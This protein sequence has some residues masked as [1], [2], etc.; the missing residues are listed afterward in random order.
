MSMIQLPKGASVAK[1]SYANAGP[2]GPLRFAGFAGD[3]G[4]EDLQHGNKYK[5]MMRDKLYGR[6]APWG[7]TFVDVGA[8]IGGETLHAAQFF[9]RVVAFEPSLRNY[10]C[11]VY[12]LELGDFKNVECWGKAV[13][14]FSG[15]S[16]LFLYPNTNSVGHSL[17][18]SVVR[19]GAP[20][21]LV[22]V[23]KLD[24][25]A[26][27]DCAML[28]VD[29]EGHDIKVLLGAEEFVSKTR[30]V[31]CMEYSPQMILRTGMSDVDLLGWC[32]K[33]NYRPYMDAGNNWAPV[34]FAMI[35]EIFRMWARTCCGWIDLYLLPSG[36]RLGGMFPE[37]PE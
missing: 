30:P 4:Y 1:E 15:T 28:H 33:M 34:S 21:Q 17:T 7:G 12:N 19:P 31:I 26:I 16:Q 23:V 9:K 35:S 13:S 11:L 6:L 8:H 29:A 24:E 25:T 37:W 2:K 5:S 32:S 22:S 27:R 10:E 14:D 36:E 3:P 18:E 20:S